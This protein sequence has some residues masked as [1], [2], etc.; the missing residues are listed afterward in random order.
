MRKLLLL[1]ILL[2]PGLCFCQNKGDNTIKLPYANYIMIKSILFKNG[3]SLT[4]S[5]TSFLTTSSKEMEHVSVAIKLMVERNDSSVFIKG[6]IKPTLSIQIY[7]VK[8]ESD[9]ENL[10]FGGAKSSPLRKAWNEMERIAMLISPN[11]VYL[12]Q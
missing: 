10:T 2:F 8:T 6:L 4:N 7:G 1:T 5:D 9:F 12:K 3:F 11:F